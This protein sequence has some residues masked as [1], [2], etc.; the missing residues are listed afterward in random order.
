MGLRLSSG[1]ARDRRP[2]VLPKAPRGGGRDRDGIAGTLLEG[3]TGTT[4]PLRYLI[5]R[6]AWHVLDHAWELE[7]KSR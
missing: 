4:W 1:L 6:A 7:D 2:A 5:R 3:S